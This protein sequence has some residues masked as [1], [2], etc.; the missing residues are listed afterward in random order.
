MD[1]DP[2][3]SAKARSKPHAASEACDEC[4]SSL[5][6][7]RFRGESVCDGCGLVFDT[8]LHVEDFDRQLYEATHLDQ[9]AV[10][11]TNA[12]GTS[13]TWKLRRKGR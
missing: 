13:T 5:T 11:Q 7:N 4:G 1:A 8:S 2:F 10:R 3:Q 12:A 6:Y 9:R